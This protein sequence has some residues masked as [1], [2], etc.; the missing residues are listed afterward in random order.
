VF[1]RTRIGIQV[2]YIADKYNIPQV[3]V[4]TIINS[5]ISYCKDLL[6][7]GERVDFF[8]LVS[9][10]PDYISTNFTA[11]LAYNCE[12][13]ANILS[14]PSHTVY[15]IMQAYIDDA[16]E[17]IQ[18]GVTVEIRGLVVCTPIY[19]DGKLSVVHSNISQSLKNV[20][21]TRHTNVTSLRVHTYKSLKDILANNLEAVV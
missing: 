13:V 1:Y 12:K 15:R 20:L 3:T 19:K 6:V 14:L 11:T 9:I 4:H 8:G 7:K 18:K 17:S 10:V 16:I 2:W 21:L 5:Y